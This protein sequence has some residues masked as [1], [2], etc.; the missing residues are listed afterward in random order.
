MGDM[1]SFWIRVDN[2]ILE[3]LNKM[4]SI[5]IHVGSEWMKHYS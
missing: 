1:D 2:G 5:S 4:Q 3:N